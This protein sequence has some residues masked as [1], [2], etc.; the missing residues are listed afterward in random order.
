[1]QVS[2][3]RISIIEKPIR[4]LMKGKIYPISPYTNNLMMVRGGDD[5]IDDLSEDERCSESDTEVEE[6]FD[7][8]SKPTQE[9]IEIARRQVALA[10]QSRNFGIATALWS[11][12]FFDTILNKVKRQHL[13]P[14]IGEASINLIPT[15]LL[16]SG[17]ALASGVSFVL[18]RDFDIRSEMESDD[19][20]EVKKGDWFL[21]LS[22]FMGKENNTKLVSQTRSLLYFHLALF[23]FFNLVAHAGYYFSTEAPF[24][25][26]SAAAINGHNTLAA[27]NAMLKEARLGELITLVLGWPLRLFAEEDRKNRSGAI[28]LLYQLS[29]I[30][31][32]ARFMSA[33]KTMICLGRGLLAA[34]DPASVINN[35]RQLSLLIASLGRLTL[36]AGVSNAL[37][38]S[39]FKSISDRIRNHP[40]FAV[41]SGISSLICFG[42]G[43][44]LLFSSLTS[45][46]RISTLLSKSFPIDAVLLMAMGTILG[47][48]STTRIIKTSKDINTY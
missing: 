7:E 9:E 38:T 20:N 13:F 15:V 6:V 35:S 34:T 48:E 22:C 17:F 23:G 10:S 42:V 43:G 47:H 31:F 45:G 12:L 8:Q 4:T 28:A 11:S 36:A 37:F 30:A 1:M 14:V 39:R 41:L 40:F 44:S 21:S 33:C 3:H 18:W 24:L 26:L 19:N 32:F 2:S 29:V 16:A 46:L 27:A 5:F 25:G